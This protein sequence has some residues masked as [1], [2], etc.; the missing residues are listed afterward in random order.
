[1]TYIGHLLTAEGL[2]V[3]PANVRAI[4]E[5]PTSTDVKGVQTLVGMINYL[6]KFYKHLS[7]DCEI[8]NLLTHK[9]SLWEWTDVQENAFRRLK[10]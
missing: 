8:L 7:D 5:M 1:M 9:D 10:D 6:S 2:K 4:T 3:D